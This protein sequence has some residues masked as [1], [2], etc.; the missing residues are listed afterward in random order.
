MIIRLATV[1][2]NAQVIPLLAKP[3]LGVVKRDDDAATTTPI[4]AQPG[5]ILGAAER[6]QTLAYGLRR[7]PNSSGPLGLGMSGVAPGIGTL[8]LAPMPPTPCLRCQGGES[9]SWQSRMP[10]GRRAHRNHENARSA[11]ECG[12]LTPPWNRAEVVAKAASSRRTPRCL[13]HK[14]FQSMKET[15]EPPAKDGKRPEMRKRC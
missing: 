2:E 12:G 11:L 4:G 13:R 3:G 10:V 9:F 8:N 6:R 15:C 1:H 14:H 5:L 7:G